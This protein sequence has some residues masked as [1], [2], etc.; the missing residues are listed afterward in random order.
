[1]ER[2][3]SAGKGI[4]IEGLTKRYGK[5]DTAVDALKGVDMRVD[6]GEVRLIGRL[7]DLFDI[8]EG[9]ARRGPQQVQPRGM[10][11]PR[12]QK[13]RHLRNVADNRLTCDIFS[14]RECQPGRIFL[15]CL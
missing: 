10:Q 9:H 6:P 4:L 8:V 3:T 11:L 15:K 1:M 5:G 13:M 14:D 7:G 12:D 2:A